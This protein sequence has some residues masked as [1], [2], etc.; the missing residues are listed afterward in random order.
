MEIREYAE[1][2]CWD[3]AATLDDVREAVTTLEEIESTARRVLGS[4]HPTTVK[5]ERKLQQSREVLSA[6]AEKE[7]LMKEV[8]VTEDVFNRITRF[9]TK[10]HQVSVLGTTVEAT[11]GD[12]EST[13]K[14]LEALPPGDA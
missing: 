4:A 12:L 11:Y 9:A 7:K 13:R 14:A 6:R 10:K 1:A 5:I 3:T 2:L 8:N